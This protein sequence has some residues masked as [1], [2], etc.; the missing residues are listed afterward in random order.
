MQECNGGE[1]TTSIQFILE[2]RDIN[3]FLLFV[4]GML[5]AAITQHKRCL[6]LILLFYGGPFTNPR[7]PSVLYFHC[8][9]WW[10]TVQGSVIHGKS[11]FNPRVLGDG[12]LL[13]EEMFF[14]CCLGIH[15]TNDCS[16]QVAR[17]G[18]TKL[19]HCTAE[20]KVVAHPRFKELQ[21]LQMWIQ[22]T[23]AFLI[24]EEGCPPICR[25]YILTPEIWKFTIKCW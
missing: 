13:Q 17:N 4:P 18:W 19:S 16:Y 20:W 5:V 9:P 22:V 23:L 10:F 3:L 25:T 8:L 11:T 6:A 2:V 24:R 12:W 7:G 1:M 15:W 21:Y 14:L